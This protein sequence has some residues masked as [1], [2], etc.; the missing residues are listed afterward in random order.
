MFSDEAFEALRCAGS[1]IDCHCSPILDIDSSGMAAHCFPLTGIVQA[2]VSDGSIA[3][4]LRELLARRVAPYRIAG[5][6][7]HC[8]SCPEKAAGAC[9]GGCVAATMRRFRSDSFRAAVPAAPERG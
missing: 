8:S 4:E 5:I 3:Q 7:P 6:Y 1:E 9:T 2:T